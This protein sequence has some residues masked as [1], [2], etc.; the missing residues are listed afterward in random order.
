MKTNRCSKLAR[1]LVLALAGAF[2]FAAAASAQ[3]P[4]WEGKFTLP[5]ETQWGGVALPTGD[6]AFRLESTALG[7]HIVTVVQGR[8]K[9]AMVM[10]Q[11]RS[12]GD[13]ARASALIVRHSGGRARIDSLHLIEL[14]D[15]FFSAPKAEGS[16]IA[17][18]PQLIQRIPVFTSGK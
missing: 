5:F 13:S 8:R 16:Q 3:E 12:Q 18:A 7:S 15:F 6:Y 4:A 1:N 17:S 11:A 10:A 9:V 2:I 14:G